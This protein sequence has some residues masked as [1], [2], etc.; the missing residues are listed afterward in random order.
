MNIGKETWRADT[1]FL[2][3]GPLGPANEKTYCS[4]SHVHVTHNKGSLCN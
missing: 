2:F 3:Q 1:T 4:T